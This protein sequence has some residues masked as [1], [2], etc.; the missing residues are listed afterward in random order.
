MATQAKHATFEGWRV[1]S[2]AFV[3]AVFGWGLGFYGPPVFLKVL[4][5]IARMA[6]R[7]DRHRRDRSF[8]RWRVFRRQ[9]GGAPSPVRCSESHQSLLDFDGGRPDRLGDLSR[10]MAHVC[11]KRAERCGM[12]RHECGRA[13]C[14]RLAVVRSQAP[15]GPRH[16]LQRRQHRRRDLLAALGCDHRGAGVCQCG[17]GYRSYNDPRPLDPRGPV[18]CP[19]SRADGACT[20]RRCAGRPAQLHH[21]GTCKT[22]A[23]PSALAGS[24]VRHAVGR[25]GVRVVRP[26]RIDCTS[27]LVAGACAR[28]ADGRI[29]NGLDHGDGYS[30]TNLARLDHAD[31]GGSP[32]CGVR[33][34]CSPIAGLGHVLSS[35]GDSIAL[36]LAGVVLFGL[37]FGNATSLPPLI[38]QV[39]FV[40]DDVT[41]A[42]ALVVGIAQA[43]YA[44]A[45]ATFGLIREFAPQL[46][47]APPGAA[48][49]C[50][51]RLP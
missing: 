41:R 14:D 50:S 6:D 4:H 19:N 1:V 31:R 27:L 49:M 9:H 44:F 39:E 11:C 21:V 10:T 42:V 24:A 18:F 16:G 35:G 2:A 33:W 20:G 17:D 8:P 48:P 45:P 30:W 51:L 32:A 3:L 25:H 13:E 46:D 34:L 40:K 15:I 12:G 23:R 37:G 7:A 29:C 43:A 47:A 38:A 5:E 26:D 28:I 36:L 22:V